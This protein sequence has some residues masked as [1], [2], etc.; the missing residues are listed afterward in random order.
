MWPGFLRGRIRNGQLVGAWHSE[1]SGGGTRLTLRGDRVFR[2]SWG[3]SPAS[4]RD[5]GT[6]SGICIAPDTDEE[7]R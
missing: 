2:G 1:I 7:A 4:E 5:G 6:W 3:L